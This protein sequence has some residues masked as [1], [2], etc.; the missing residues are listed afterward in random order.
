MF[1]TLGKITA[2]YLAAQF[3]HKAS[4]LYLASKSEDEGVQATAEQWRNE[5]FVIKRMKLDQKLS[6]YYLQ[7]AVA[8]DQS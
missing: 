7:E 8:N 4:V 3:I 6:F 2:A 5:S 1:K